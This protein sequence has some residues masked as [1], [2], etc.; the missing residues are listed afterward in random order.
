[1]RRRDLRRKM[2]QDARAKI[3]ASVREQRACGARR[4]WDDAEVATL[5]KAYADGGNPAVREAFP[6]LRSS[7]LA[8]AV[9]RYCL[10]IATAPAHQK[11]QTSVWDSADFNRRFQ[12]ALAGFTWR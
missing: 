6:H 10:V 8:S 3:A 5:R 2:P 1:M 12:E 4:V 11:P 9:R 7:Q